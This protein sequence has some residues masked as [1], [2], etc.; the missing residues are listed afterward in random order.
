MSILLAATGRGPIAVP[1]L[2]IDSTSPSSPREAS[3]SFN[4][5]GTITG[6]LAAVVGNWFAVT[7]T[8]IGNSYEI[9]AEI[10]EGVFSAGTFDAWLSLG[11]TQQW[12]FSN[13][14]PTVAFGVIEFSIRPNGVDIILA[15][16]QVTLRA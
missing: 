13:G 7:T 15:T 16:G 12:T 1:F 6:E 11:T 8:G 5:N 4:P 3:V 10:V 14:E 9:R 2:T